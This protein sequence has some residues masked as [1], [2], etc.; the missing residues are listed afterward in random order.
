[1]AHSGFSQTWHLRTGH[2][3]VGYTLPGL[4]R[5]P[6]IQSR[7][8]VPPP[9][10]LPTNHRWCADTPRPEQFL[11]SGLRGGGGGSL[12]PP[13]GRH[14]PPPE[15]PPQPLP[16]RAV[17]NRP[18]CARAHHP[19]SLFPLPPPPRPSGAARAARPASGERAPLA[20][21]SWGAGLN[22]TP[23]EGGT[24]R[25]R[26]SRR[27]RSPAA[28]LLAPLPAAIYAPSPLPPPPPRPPGTRRLARPLRH[29]AL[30]RWAGPAACARPGPARSRRPQRGAGGEGR[31]QRLRRRR[32]SL[33]QRRAL[34]GGPGAPGRALPATGRGEAGGA[35]RGAAGG[36]S[37]RPA[38]G[39]HAWTPRAAAGAPRDARA[40]P[41]GGLAGWGG[42]VGLARLGQG[43]ALSMAGRAL[44]ARRG[45]ANGCRTLCRVRSCLGVA[46]LVYF[47]F[48]LR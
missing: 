43:R 16:R 10:S 8:L 1:M 42:S 40:G 12:P 34:L 44:S 45:R 36:S 17:V 30:L 47:G 13:T 35:S 7:F 22:E 33:P 18:R 38:A 3:G 11:F 19:L 28:F 48:V 46:F 4:E 32:V 24:H 20:A 9:P 41:G 14:A 2:P 27:H 25:R 21:S 26:C 5:S 15:K 31:G 6:V 37:G 29:A 39:P 23:R